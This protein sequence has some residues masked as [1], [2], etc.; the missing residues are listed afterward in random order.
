[1]TCPEHSTI[2]SCHP[3]AVP[4]R[5]SFRRRRFGPAYIESQGGQAAGQVEQMLR[6]ERTLAKPQ[7]DRMLLEKLVIGNVFRNRLIDSSIRG[8]SAPPFKDKSFGPVIFDG[9]HNTISMSSITNTTIHSDHSFPLAANES[10]F[11]SI[12]TCSSEIINNGT[13]FPTDTEIAKLP[14]ESTLCPE[15]PL[16][17]DISSPHPTVLDNITHDDAFSTTGTLNISSGVKDMQQITT[18]SIGHEPCVTFVDVNDSN[19]ER[20]DFLT[21]SGYSNSLE[22]TPMDTPFRPDTAA[23]NGYYS[24]LLSTMRRVGLVGTHTSDRKNIL[25]DAAESGKSVANVLAQFGIKPSSRLPTNSV[26]SKSKRSQKM[27][28]KRSVSSD[29]WQKKSILVPAPRSLSNST[30]HIEA[31]IDSAGDLSVD[32]STYSTSDSLH[33][34]SI[35]YET[36]DSFTEQSRVALELGENSADNKLS[37]KLIELAKEDVLERMS[38]DRHVHQ[39]IF[40]QQEP[41]FHMELTRKV[42]NVLP[43]L[44]DRIPD[45]V[46]LD[47][48]QNSM[49][50]PMDAVPNTLQSDNLKKSMTK[51]E[52][53]MLIL[54]TRMALKSSRVSNSLPSA[55][56]IGCSNTKTQTIAD[57]S[58]FSATNRRPLTAS[59]KQ[60]GLT[61]TENGIDDKMAPLFITKYVDNLRKV[62]L[63]TI[64]AANKDWSFGAEK[65]GGNRATNIR[66]NKRSPTFTIKKGDGCLTSSIVDTR[67]ESQKEVSDDSISIKA[68][69]TIPASFI[70]TITNAQSQENPI[71]NFINARRGARFIEKGMVT[72]P[73]S[74]NYTEGEFLYSELSDK[75]GKFSNEMADFHKQMM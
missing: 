9:N 37:I 26:I 36:K 31:V 11:S 49:A 68:S 65:G 74:F 13:T 61:S 3:P 19:K 14:E 29:T 20:E 39:S 1:M 6:V 43:S 41:H 35:K 54:N 28:P 47:A 63:N 51:E 16:E 18:D 2:T 27:T 7:T 70:N 46:I 40:R 66:Y 60:L 30:V 8:N 34:R 10:D 33:N 71:E 67:S 58:K 56:V 59:I 53:S 48:L 12:L 21:D 55:C 52:Q 4:T 42:G 73:I 69:N 24:N 44:I 72:Q 32:R 22:I 50:I 17:A 57:T 45:A 15:L 25:L 23:H 75:I 38:N 64:I 62:D 5:N